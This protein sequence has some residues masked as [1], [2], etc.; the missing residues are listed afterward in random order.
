[1]SLR[2]ANRTYSIIKSFIITKFSCKC[3]CNSQQ[4]NESKQIKNKCYW[5]DHRRYFAAQMHAN[6]WYVSVCG[7]CDSLV[8]IVTRE[9]NTSLLAYMAEV[10]IRKKRH[11]HSSLV[12][13]SLTW[14]TQR[15][16]HFFSFVSPPPSPD[17]FGFAISHIRIQKVLLK[18]VRAT[19]S[20][21]HHPSFLTR[22]WISIVTIWHNSYPVHAT[23]HR[24]CRPESKFKYWLIYRIKQHLRMRRLSIW[25]RTSRFRLCIVRPIWHTLAHSHLRS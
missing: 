18:D 12:R 22:L 21:R 8:G 25:H 11:A 20:E 7:A 17:L 5:K 19:G 1:M 14:Y 9:I 4:F 16:F 13:V 10:E 3:S 15:L 24:M 23:R 2:T 6:A